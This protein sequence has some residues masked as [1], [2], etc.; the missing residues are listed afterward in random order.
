MGNNVLGDRILNCYKERQSLAYRNAYSF[1]AGDLLTIVINDE[2]EMQ[3]AW[4]QHDFSKEYMP[5]QTQNK[6][7]VRLMN[8]WRQARPEFL[9]EGRVLPLPAYECKKYTLA[10][11]QGD[12]EVDTVLGCVYQASNGEKALFL[13]NWTDEPQIVKCAEFAGKRVWTSPTESTNVSG[14]TLEIPVRSVVMLEI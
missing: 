5:E 4:I 11:Y 9:L 14:E 10:I 2:G 12:Q 7:F 3:W 8:E 1:I 6:A 13:V